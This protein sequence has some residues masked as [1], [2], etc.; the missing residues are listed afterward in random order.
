M[1]Q[2]PGLNDLRVFEAAA[3]LQNFRQAAEELHLTHGAVSH[4]IRALEDQLN[5]SLFARQNGVTLTDAGRE[6][7]RSAKQAL[8]LIANTIEQIQQHYADPLPQLRLAVLPTFAARWLLPR[9]SDFH[10]NHAELTL[11]IEASADLV[12]VG[13][14]GVDAAIRLGTGHWKDLQ[15]ELMLRDY[16][17][18]VASAAFVHKYN[19]T[20]PRDLFDV[21]LLAHA[22]RPGTGL[23]WKDYFSRLKIPVPQPLQMTTFDD[24]NLVIQAAEQGMGVALVRHSLARLGSEQNNLQPLF[25]FALPSDHHYYFVQAATSSQKLA[26]QQLLHWLKAQ[27][28]QFETEQVD[29]GKHWQWLP[30]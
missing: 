6:L 19:L 23:S 27:V 16:Y 25:N 24:G 22:Y 9:L 12:E 10:A 1:R 17:Y 13:A 15:S 11:Q 30:S 2:I 5:V 4:R 14:K 21:P 18:P 29:H 20:E 3:R 8:D 26:T 28:I 7:Y